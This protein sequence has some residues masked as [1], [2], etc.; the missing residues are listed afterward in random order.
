MQTPRKFASGKKN[1]PNEPRRI[2][3]ACATT[4][5]D[6][7]NPEITCRSMML[8]NFSDDDSSPSLGLISRSISPSYSKLTTPMP[9]ARRV[10]SIHIAARVAGENPSTARRLNLRAASAHWIKW[11][12]DGNANSSTKSTGE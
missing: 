3:F 8:R 12:D 7:L 2:S 11:G 4:Q 6:K 10:P 9:A 1:E 5:S